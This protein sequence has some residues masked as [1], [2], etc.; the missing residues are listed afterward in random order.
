MTYEEKRCNHKMQGAKKNISDEKRGNT[1]NARGK[2]KLLM[3]KRNHKHEKA[4]MIPNEKD[5]S[6]DDKMPKGK[7]DVPFTM[8]N[9]YLLVPY[10]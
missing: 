10:R 2:K 3:I 9:A 5:T 1:K 4:R 8:T 6:L 7:W